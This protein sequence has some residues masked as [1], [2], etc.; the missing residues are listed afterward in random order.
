M[1]FPV[2]LV[3]PEAILFEGEASIVIA[4]GIDGELGIQANHAPIIVALD[5]GQLFIRES[6]GTQVR[7]AVHGGFL[8]MS[9]NVCTVLADV[10]EVSEQI[11]VGRAQE[12]LERAERAERAGDG[13]AEAAAKRARTRLDVAG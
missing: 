10:A 1:P 5:I 2:S 9:N 7:A 6:D 8:E 13:E 12:A 4:R 3:T 11:D